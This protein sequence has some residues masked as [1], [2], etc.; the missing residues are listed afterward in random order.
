MPE[1][2]MTLPSSELDLLSALD[3]LVSRYK[4]FEINRH[5]CEEHGY[6]YRCCLQNW[7]GTNV[8]SGVGLTITEAIRS[9]LMTAEEAMI[10]PEQLAWEPTSEEI[11]RMFERRPGNFLTEPPRVVISDRR[12]PMLPF[13]LSPRVITVLLVLGMLLLA[14]LN[15][16]GKGWP[17]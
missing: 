7:T 17:W 16:A 5:G 10:Y 14:L 4:W 6:R 11:S 8:I 2:R 12:G 9:C 3:D 1:P 15:V 13:G